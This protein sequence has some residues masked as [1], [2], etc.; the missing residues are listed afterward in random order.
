MHWAMK[1]SMP[2]SM[3]LA[4]GLVEMQVTKVRLHG[5]C[6][7]RAGNMQATLTRSFAV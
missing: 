1:K 5:V 4:D 2:S 6:V 7:T 3:L